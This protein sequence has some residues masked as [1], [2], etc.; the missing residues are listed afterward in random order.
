MNNFL[1]NLQ[2]TSGNQSPTKQTTQTLKLLIFS[3]D[4]LKVALSID[5]VKKVINYTPVHGSGLNSV[6]IAHLEDREITVVDLHHRLFKV[7]QPVTSGVRAYFILA[8]NSI[9][10]EF[11]IIVS[12]A[13]T[14]L[15]VPLSTIRALPESYR[16]ADTLEIA[17][18]VM[19]IPQTPE[20]ITVFLLDVDR[21]VPPVV[22]N[23]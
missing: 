3:V 6:G 8:N 5:V 21:L 19:M 15:D 7:S 13:P 12:Q 1:S 23:Q 18:H 4:K 16:R 22:M 14:L 2:L 10:E 20:S 9:K 11:G 17:T